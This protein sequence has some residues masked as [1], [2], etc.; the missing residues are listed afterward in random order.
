LNVLLEYKIKERTHELECSRNELLRSL[1]ERDMLIDRA[2]SEISQTVKSIKGLCF[3]AREDTAGG[4]VEYIERIER[5]LL[6]IN[7]EL[8]LFFQKA[9]NE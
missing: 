2:A 7:S 5:T 1:G 6:K 9:A 3:T 4:A 8:Q